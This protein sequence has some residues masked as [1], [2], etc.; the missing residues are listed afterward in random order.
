MTIVERVKFC[1]YTNILH[2]STSFRKK[3]LKKDGKYSI[4][5]W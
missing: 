2:K 5:I 1:N 4:I 3:A